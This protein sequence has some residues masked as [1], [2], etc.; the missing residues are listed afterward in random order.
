MRRASRAVRAGGRAAGLPDA[1]RR[2]PDV[3]EPGFHGVRAPWIRGFMAL[4]RGRHVQ[5]VM[6]M[7]PA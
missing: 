7:V 3:L 4:E 1:G 6:L 2:A 5:I